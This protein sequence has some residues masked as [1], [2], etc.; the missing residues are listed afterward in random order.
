MSPI[1]DPSA[2]TSGAEWQIGG[3]DKPAAAGE[4]SGGFG[5]ILGSQISK[6]TDLQNQAADASQQLATGQA[7]DPTAVVMAVERAQLA[8]QLAGQLRTKGVEALNDIL[9]TQV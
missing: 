6:L 8:M 3:V 5:N 7:T 1:V 9:H 4:S 2:I